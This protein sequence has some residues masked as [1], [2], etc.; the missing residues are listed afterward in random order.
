VERKHS[1][2]R[3]EAK[4]VLAE[5]LPARLAH[6][7][8]ETCLP[9]GPMA[10][11]PDRS[12]V[13]FAARLKRWEVQPIGSERWAKAEVTLGGIDTRELSS[14]TMEARDVPGLYAIGDPVESAR[15]HDTHAGFTDATR[16]AH[17][18]HAI[19]PRHE[20]RPH[21]GG[22]WPTVLGDARANSAD[23]GQGTAETQTPEPIK[24]PQNLPR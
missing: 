21:A 2:P 16:G 8:A 15:D 19:W 9:P 6:A 1:R 10:N 24:D 14:K 20:Q 5:I 7:L 3:A 22:S 23:R 17:R 18:A 12:L 4:T 11:I 13:A